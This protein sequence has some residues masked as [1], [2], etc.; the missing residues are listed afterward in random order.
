[1]RT[2]VTGARG[3]LGGAVADMLDRR[4]H[5]VLQH[6]GRTQ[7]DLVDAAVTREFLAT[8]QPTAVVHCAAR[9]DSEACQSNPERARRDNVDA[10][11]ALVDAAHAV[12]AHFIYLSTAFVFDGTKGEPYEEGDTPNPLSVYAQTKYAGEAVV[13]DADGPWAIV[14][15]DWLYGARGASF[16]KLM[17]TQASVGDVCRVV[18]DEVGSPTFLDDLAEALCDLVEERE[19]GVFHLTNHGACSAAH[20]AEAIFRLAGLSAEIEPVTRV[21]LA[22]DRQRAPRPSYHALLSHRWE[23][24]GHAPLRPWEAALAAYLDQTLNGEVLTPSRPRSEER[25]A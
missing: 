6:L 12:G 14:R 24:T 2:V 20:W 4:G 25:P 5:V 15:S 17:L 1:M 19:T 22:A 23:Q 21:Q 3:R 8:F 16:P 13:Q 18:E 10:T 11:R 7:F 9:T